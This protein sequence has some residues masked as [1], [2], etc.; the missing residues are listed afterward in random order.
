MELTK[1]PRNAKQIVKEHILEILENLEMIFTRFAISQGLQL[2]YI[3]YITLHIWGKGV[4]KTTKIQH[5][6]VKKTLKISKIFDH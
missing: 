4:L 1:T 6:I 5:T 3:L 2:I